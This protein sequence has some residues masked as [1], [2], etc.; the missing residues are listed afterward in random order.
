MRFLKTKNSKK[1]ISLCSFKFWEKGF[2]GKIKKKMKW[3][4][5]GKNKKYSQNS[6]RVE[7]S[8]EILFLSQKQSSSFNLK[9][10]KYL[11]KMIN[12]TVCKT[13]P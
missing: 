12:E 11:G 6:L 9:K 3:N 13:F 8:V 4:N 7:S 1:K 2:Q 10:K 5:S